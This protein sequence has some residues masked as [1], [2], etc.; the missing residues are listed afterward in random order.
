MRPE[1]RPCAAKITREAVK[2]I[3]EQA[4]KKASSRLGRVNQS[5]ALEASAIEAGSLSKAIT[6]LAYG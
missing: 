1:I 3:A 5:Q 4:L 2:Q 6:D